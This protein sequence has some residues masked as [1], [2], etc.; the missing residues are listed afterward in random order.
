[1]RRSALAIG[2]LGLLAT[3][4]A[5]ALLPRIRPSVAGTPDPYTAATLFAFLALP[6]LI[7]LAA[8][9]RG[10]SRFAIASGIP[11]LGV[12][13]AALGVALLHPVGTLAALLYLVK[14]IGQVLVCLPLGG[15]IT[16]AI[17]RARVIAAGRASS[18]K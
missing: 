5:F 2:V 4:I 16:W 14:P 12:E 1:M 17:S 15:V 6:W 8:A 10:A 11:M 18:P 3:P 13:A 9:W 7:V